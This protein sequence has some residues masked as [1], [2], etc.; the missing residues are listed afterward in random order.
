MSFISL[1]LLELVHSLNIRSEYSLFEVG[2]FKNK[3]IIFAFLLGAILQLAVVTIPPIANI[4][5]VVMLTKGQWIITAIISI[6]PLFI[7]EF[8]KKIKEICFGRTIYSMSE[9]KVK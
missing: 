4:F 5:E 8:S 6:S 7:M 2:F 1:S 3:Y 9:S